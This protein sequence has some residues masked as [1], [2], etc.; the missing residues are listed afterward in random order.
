M[1]GVVCMYGELVNGV[2]YVHGCGDCGVRKEVAGGCRGVCK[3]G[4]FVLVCINVLC[5]CK[6]CAEFM[7]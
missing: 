3:Y 7:C 6:C 1:R 5:G 4:V 2:R